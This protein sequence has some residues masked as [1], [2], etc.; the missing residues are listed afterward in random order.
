MSKPNPNVNRMVKFAEG[1]VASILARMQEYLGISLSFRSNTGQVVVK[2]D[3]FNG[4]CCVIRGAQIGMQRC[5]RTYHMIEEK[6]LRRKVPMVTVCYAGFLV[7]AVPLELRGEM[8]GSLLGSQIL[9]V[10]LSSEAERRAYS[11]HLITSLGI[12]D[13]TAFLKS[14]DRVRYLEPDFGRVTFL[15]FLAH[16]GDHFTQLAFTGKSW[17]EFLKEIKKDLH[18]NSF[19]F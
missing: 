2:T 5:R 12:E 1:Q 16:L 10:R 3:Y 19:R 11:L 14:Y 4:P 7:F 17:P 15:D 13:E 9:P 18:A 8:I 6:L